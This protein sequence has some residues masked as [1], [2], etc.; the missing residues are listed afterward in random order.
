MEFADVWLKNVS[1]TEN[2][3]FKVGIAIKTIATSG[4]KQ[5][6]QV[7]L[8]VWKPSRHIY[9]EEWTLLKDNTVTGNV[10]KTYR[11]E[12]KWIMTFKVLQDKYLTWSS[13]SN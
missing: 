7:I 2:M 11:E 6:N 12:G 4:I 1:K 3:Q 8:V 9:I 13:E 5:K 10:E